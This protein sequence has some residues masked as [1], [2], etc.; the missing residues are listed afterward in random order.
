LIEHLAFCAITIIILYGERELM[1]RNATGMIGMIS[2]ITI[3]AIFL[4]GIAT[5]GQIGK[6]FSQTNES[7]NMTATSSNAS[8]MEANIT[9]SNTNDTGMGAPHASNMTAAKVLAPNGTAPS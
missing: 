3:T 6:V 1:I 8:S 2:A 9:G 4:S 7:S 5:T